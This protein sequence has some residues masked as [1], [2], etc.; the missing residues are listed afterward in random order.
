MLGKPATLSVGVFQRTFDRREYFVNHEL[1]L[2][3]GFTGK[4]KEN[5]TRR[6]KI[7]RLENEWNLA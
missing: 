1:C 2:Q 3:K 5:A 4:N 7:F 6:V